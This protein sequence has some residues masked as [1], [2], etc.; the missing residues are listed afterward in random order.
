MLT[1]KIGEAL[2]KAP[3]F[4]S[5]LNE[6]LKILYSYWDVRHSFISFFDPESQT[7]KIVSAFGLTKE[8]IKRAIFKKGEGMVG[9]VFKNELPILLQDLEEKGYLNKLGLKDVVE[10]GTSFL[11]VPL[12]TADQVLGVFG[13]FKKFKEGESKEKALELLQTLGTFISITYLIN[14]KHSQ[15]R[16][17]WE[18]EKKLLTQTL[19]EN[20]GQEG[21]IGKSLAI[22]N[23]IKLVKKV[24]QTTANVLITGESGTGKSFIAKAIHF[25]SPRKNK[26]FVA[27]NCSHSRNPT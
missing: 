18:E 23:L 13:V 26:P 7:L 17:F 1:S 25:L 8:Q 3:S 22:Q 12:K 11:A 15:E 4:A 21:I 2:V 6:V 24:A 14:K 9:K 19:Y 5:A 27:V 16:A 10:R 20:F